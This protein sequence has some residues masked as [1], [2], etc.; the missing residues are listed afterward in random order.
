M[1]DRTMERRTGT[2]T[3]AR[4]QEVLARMT[5]EE[6]A[7]LTVGRAAWTTVCGTWPRHRIARSGRRQTGRS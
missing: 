5:L 2:T 7:A 1:T 4:V 6:K 3:G